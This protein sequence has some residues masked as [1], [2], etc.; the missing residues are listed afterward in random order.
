VD[1]AGGYRTAVD[2]ANVIETLMKLDYID[3]II[4]NVPINPAA[5]GIQVEKSTTAGLAA[6]TMRT[7]EAGTRQFCQLPW[8]YNKP[9]ACVR[10][11]TDA[12]QDTVPQKLMEAGIPVYETP[13]QCA[14]AMYALA[15][16]AETRRANKSI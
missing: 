7:V 12:Q 13:E 1:F 6:E 15:R 10:W 5:W 14:R 2:E 8:K 11:S 4:S 16:Y 3:G 9:I